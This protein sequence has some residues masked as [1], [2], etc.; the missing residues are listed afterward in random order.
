MKTAFS[1]ACIAI[2]GADALEVS[3]WMAGGKKTSTSGAWGSHG[4]KTAGGFKHTSTTGGFGGKK[5]WPG[6]KYSTWA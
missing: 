4:N 6:K 1:L 5:M 3:K 2:L